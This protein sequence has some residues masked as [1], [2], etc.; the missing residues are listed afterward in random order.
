MLNESDI[1]NPKVENEM[2]EMKSTSSPVKNILKKSNLKRVQQK[3][4][5]Q[6]ISWGFGSTRREREV[7]DGEM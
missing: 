2:R 4:Y 3:S 6:S 1:A 5:S 7:D